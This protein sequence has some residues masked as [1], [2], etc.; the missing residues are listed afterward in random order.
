MPKRR[1]MSHQNSPSYAAE[2]NEMMVTLSQEYAARQKDCTQATEDLGAHQS[3]ALSTLQ[4]MGR[5]VY[6]YPLFS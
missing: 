2:V 1:D 5:M 3:V 4:A 6:I